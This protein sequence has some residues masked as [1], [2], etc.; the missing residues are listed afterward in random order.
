MTP[1]TDLA[2]AV[3]AGTAF[4]AGAWLLLLLTPRWGAVGLEQRIAPYIR[5]VSD[6]QGLTPLATPPTW[7]TRIRA[8]W[9]RMLSGSDAV[10]RRLRQAGRSGGRE[11]VT[12][13]RT[14]QLVWG[15]GGVVVGALA[16]VLVVLTGRPPV[17]AVLLPALAGLAGLAACDLLLTQAARARVSRIEEEL[18]T[19][20]E[21]LALCLSAG[22]G[23]LDSLRRVGRLEGGELTSEL[24]DVV[25]AVGTGSSLAEA[26]T[27]FAHEL[28]VPCLNRSVDHIAAALDR[29]APL[30]QVLQAQAADAREDAKQ[31][32]IERAGRNEIKMMLP[33]VFL[34]LPISV[35]FAIFPGVFMLRLGIG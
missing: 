28:D 13:F 30:A 26:L 31:T 21:F 22:E 23:I 8:R 35:L 9:D 33:L 14:R 24:R 34:I 20:L 18:P 16:G 19:V 6:P 29:G 27:A 25:L 11:G 1:I 2:M 4:G 5:D 15:L 32:L 7:S 17:A 12:S 10:S 3:V